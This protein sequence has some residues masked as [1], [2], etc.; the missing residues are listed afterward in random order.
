M[1]RSF[2]VVLLF[3]MS[4]WSATSLALAV[5]DKAPQFAAPSLRDFKLLKLSQYRGQVVYLEFWASWCPQC[6]DAVS[7][8]EEL[9]QEFQNNGVVVIGVNIDDEMT[10][11]RT[12][13]EKLG[14]TYALV[15]PD[16]DDVKL[17]YDVQAMPYGVLIDRK[18][19]VR[20]TGEGMNFWKL[21]K[22]K[23]QVRQLL[24]QK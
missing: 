21:R 14:A 23:A 8:V 2:L 9:H 22:L 13:I 6:W 7:S 10:D 4:L 12:A 5:G 24:G 15:R 1:R 20:Y 19:V 17:A 18:G 3:A 11:A 16:Q